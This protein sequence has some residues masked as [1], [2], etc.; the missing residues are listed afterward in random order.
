MIVDQLWEISLVLV[1]ATAAL[2][3]RISHIL[4]AE[5]IHFHLNAVRCNNMCYCY[6]MRAN[7]STDRTHVFRERHE[8]KNRELLE[9]TSF[10]VFVNVIRIYLC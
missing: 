10:L 4:Y 7:I 2:L 5:F 3:I 1:H 9:L 6:V 8:K